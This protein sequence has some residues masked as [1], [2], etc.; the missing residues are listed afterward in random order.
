MKDIEFLYL[1]QADVRAT[2]A[3]MAMVMDAV[4]DS[5]RLHHQGKTNLP[6]KTVLDMG[7]RERGRGNAMPAYVG[8]EYD[9]FGIKWIAGFPK[10]PALHGLPRATGFFILNDSSTGVPLAIMDCTL[11]SAMR[12]GAVTGVGAKYLARPDS[13]SAA[14]IGAGVQARTQLE[15]LKVAL[16]GLREVR[17]FD[18]HRAT[19]DAYAAEMSKMLSMDV[20]AVD[21]AE[22]AVCDADVVV[23]VTV[24]DEPIVKEAWMKPGSFFSAVGSYQEE[25]FAV[26]ENS[27]KVVVDGLEHV[28]HR[29]TPVIALMVAQGTIQEAN[30]L[31]LSAIVG[32]EAPGRE[33]PGERI[34]FSP[35]GMGTHDVCACNNVYRLAVEKGIGTKLRLFGAE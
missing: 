28:L 21:T 3:D 23:T 25:E 35:I 8:G 16:P 27:D 11:L 22:A 2:G 24:A 15:A 30:I 1:T 12:T 26:V 7:E 10:N 29:E 9:V 34:F 13:E 19:A 6:H 31:E 33:T 4:E 5:F 32:G 20:R 14:M 17:A 18:I